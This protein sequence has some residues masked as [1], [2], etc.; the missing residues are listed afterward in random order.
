[1]RPLPFLALAL[2]SAFAAE[3]DKTPDGYARPKAGRQFTFPRDHG[4]HPEF[5]IE[6]WYLTGHLQAEDGRRFGVQATFFRRADGTASRG[7][8]YLAHIALL[9]VKG[10]RFM[11]QERLNREGWDAGAAVG[12]LDVKC[13]PWSLRMDDAGSI[14]VAGSVRA[15]A[16]F[17]LDLKPAK[18]LVVFGENGVSRKGADPTAASHYLTF[19]RL[20]TRGTLMLGA[21]KIALRGEMWM[22][23]EMSSSQLDEG[24]VGWDWA[25]LQLRDGREAMVYRMRRKDE[26]A[27]PF[28][29]LAWVDPAGAVQRVSAKDFALSPIAKWRSPHSGAEYPSGVS[30]SALDPATGQRVQW[31]L[32]PLAQDQELTGRI[33]GI[34]YWEGACRVLDEQDKE[35]GSAFLELTGYTGDLK[36]G[37]R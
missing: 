31:K 27:D 9:D 2:V 16:S 1:M 10:G 21:E 33:T 35:I 18:P 17:Q 36:R 7:N 30:L 34:A 12:S 37:L 6:W 20:E 5:K 3:P 22:D 28:S 29:T 14:H 23:H 4:S 15:E 24:Q 11:H 32:V 26:T 19:P 25:C 8:I 13:G